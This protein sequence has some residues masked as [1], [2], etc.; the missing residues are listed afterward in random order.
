MHRVFIGNLEAGDHEL[1]GAVHGPGPHVRDYR[2]GA[3][4]KLD[5]GRRRQVCRAQDT[6]NRAPKEQPEF[7]VKE[8]E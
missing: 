7:I 2:R 3:T 5:Q 6:S 1:L 4:I 8:W